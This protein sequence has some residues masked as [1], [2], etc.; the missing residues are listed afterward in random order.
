MVSA[1]RS[2]RGRGSGRRVRR[3]RQGISRRAAD[4]VRFA[5]SPRQNWH[6]ERCGRDDAMKTLG[7]RRGE[8]GMTMGGTVIGID[9]HLDLAMNALLWNRDLRQSVQTIREQERGM[10]QKGRG[11]G[12]VSFPELRRA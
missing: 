6:R 1:T 9:G 10:T 3:V 12:T 2:T 11:G 5:A 4:R 8:T 7:V